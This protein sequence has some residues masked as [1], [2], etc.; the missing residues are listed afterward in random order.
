MYVKFRYQYSMPNRRRPQEP[1]IDQITK[2]KGKV[3]KIGLDED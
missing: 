2:P 3:R 1:S